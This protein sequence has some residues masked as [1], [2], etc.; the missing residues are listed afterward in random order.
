MSVAVETVNIPCWC[1][2]WF[3]CVCYL[4]VPAVSFSSEL[5]F[6]VIIISIS[7]ISS[8]SS[9]AAAAQQQQQEQQ[10][11]LLLTQVCAKHR[12]S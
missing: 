6:S 12:F 2:C 1:R 8:S 5:D 11:L 7:S 3:S 10:H 9:T 4:V